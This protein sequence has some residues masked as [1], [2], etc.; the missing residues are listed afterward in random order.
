MTLTVTKFFNGFV[1]LKRQGKQILLLATSPFETTGFRY[2]F[3]CS[4][5]LDTLLLLVLFLWYTTRSTDSTESPIVYRLFICHWNINI[6]HS[7][8]HRPI[9]MSGPIPYSPFIGSTSAIGRYVSTTCKEIFV[10]HNCVKYQHINREVGNIRFACMHH[11]CY[12]GKVDFNFLLTNTKQSL[13]LSDKFDVL[14]R[15]QFKNVVQ[16]NWQI[17]AFLGLKICNHKAILQTEMHLW[18]INNNSNIQ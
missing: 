5:V 4:L 14:G 1:Y 18:H 13:H 2:W 8:N 11:R 16:Q 3:G 9:F 10:L 15:C 6:E 17:C 12:S 7:F